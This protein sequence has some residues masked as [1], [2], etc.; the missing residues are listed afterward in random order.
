MPSCVVSKIQDA[1]AGYTVCDA[2][3]CGDGGNDLLS[4]GDDYCIK[5]WDSRKSGAGPLASYMGH[6]SC[7][8]SF[9]TI[10]L[11]N[12]FVCSFGTNFC[13]LCCLS[14][15]L[16]FFIL[17]SVVSVVSFLWAQTSAAHICCSQ[18]WSSPNLSA[19]FHCFQ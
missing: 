9:A 16:V 19:C 2:L 15:I 1:A 10:C 3:W 14:E 12:M 5:M 4:A 11:A 18:S 7:V 6:T 13:M 8:R 17:P